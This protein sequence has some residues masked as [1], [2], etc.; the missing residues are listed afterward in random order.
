MKD[1]A[2]DINWLRGIN[3]CK[4]T[5]NGLNALHINTPQILHRDLKT[6]NL[7]V[8]QEWHI[9]LADFGLSRFDTAENIETMKQMRGTYQYLD[10]S[11]YGGG[12][13][14]AASDIYS[15]SII[16]WEIVNR[17]ITRTYVQPYAEF[18]NLKFDFQI[19]VQSATNGLRPTIPSNCPPAFRELIVD[20]WAPSQQARPSLEQIAQ[21]LGVIE[22]QYLAHQQEWDALKKGN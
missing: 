5:A 9:K 20:C 8:T 17:V 10:P 2:A 4:E 14:T 15:M 6:L 12:I 22:E 16:F 19:I 7:L 3:F 13:F 21:T 11:V 18:S 1:P